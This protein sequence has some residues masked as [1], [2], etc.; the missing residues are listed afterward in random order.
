MRTFGW[1]QQFIP[2][3]IASLGFVNI[4][5]AE[6]KAQVGNVIVYIAGNN[7]VTLDVTRQVVTNPII[8]SVN[9]KTSIVAGSFDLQTADFVT[10]ELQ[11]LGLAAQQGYQTSSVFQPNQPVSNNPYVT[12]PSYLPTDPVNMNNNPSKYRYITGVPVRN[13]DMTS[14]ARVRQFIPNAF[15]SKSELGDYIYAGGYTNRDAAESLKHFLRSQGVD[16]RVI[17]F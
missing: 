16:A 4:A 1:L 11:R 7:P 3:A 13:G 12:L 15:I 17:Y 14:L 6:A 9:G 5:I 10:R 8:A 2:M